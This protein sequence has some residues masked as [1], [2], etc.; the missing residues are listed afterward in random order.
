M[1]IHDLCFADSEGPGLTFDHFQG[2]RYKNTGSGDQHSEKAGALPGGDLQAASYRVL[3]GHLFYPFS[4]EQ[5]TILPAL[6]LRNF[7]QHLYA[8]DQDQFK[9]HTDN[10]TMLSGAMTVI[11]SPSTAMPPSLNHKQSRAPMYVLSVKQSLNIDAP[12]LGRQSNLFL[13]AIL[14]GS[15]EQSQIFAAEKAQ[16]LLGVLARRY[17]FKDFFVPVIGIKLQWH[18]NFL[19]DLSYP[20]KFYGQLNLNKDQAISAG[21]FVLARDYSYLIEAEYPAVAGT[22]FTG[23][24][25]KGY[26]LLAAVGFRQRIAGILHGEIKAG[27]VMDKKELYD[28]SSGDLLLQESSQVVPAIQLSL[29]TVI[30]D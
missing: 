7:Q 24:W 4:V 17:P 3:D 15:S 13:G 25:E 14:F 27:Y 9:H 8:E 21:V 6:Q 26:G 2:S 10:F 30:A 16:V 12:A 5:L 20:H 28:H 18:E 1:L 22:K 23:V 29:L 11:F 19:A